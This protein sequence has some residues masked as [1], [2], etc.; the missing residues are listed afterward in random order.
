MCYFLINKLNNQAFAMLLSSKIKVENHKD[1][2]YKYLLIEDIQDNLIFK[3]KKNSNKESIRHVQI[4]SVI[5]YYLY[6]N[7]FKIKIY[8][9][10]C[11]Q[12]DYFD[13]L[14]NSNITNKTTEN[15]LKCGENI[16]KS[17]SE[18]KTIWDKLIE[19]NPFIDEYQKDYILY[20]DTIVQDDYLAKE[21]SK[22]YNLLKNNKSQ[23]KN[24]VYHS[25]F[26]VNTSSILLID[27]YLLNGKIVYASPNFSLLFM[28]D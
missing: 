16:F 21:E 6:I 4:G 9:G 27:G 12:I 14:K 25:M 8:D 19:L 15:L 11:N 5:L 23:E 18:I 2:Y 20:L 24:N 10:L 7:L 17:H 1:L 13:L 22:K 3:L 28:Y 26:L